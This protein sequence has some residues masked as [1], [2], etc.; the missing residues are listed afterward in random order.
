MSTR[1]FALAWF[2]GLS[3]ISGQA[4]ATTFRG[5]SIAATAGWFDTGVHLEA[6]DQLWISAT[7]SASPNGFD[8]F[9]GPDGDGGN[10]DTCIS[11]LPGSRYAL[12]GRIG[13]GGAPFLVGSS[14]STVVSESGALFLGFNDDFHGDNAGSFA[15]DGVVNPLF[16]DLAIAA[17][18]GWV[19]TGIEVRAGDLLSISATGSASPNGVD[20]FQGP[21][22]DGGNCDTCIVM[23]PGSRYALVGRIG[24]GGAPFIVGSSFSA[25]V[26]DAG[27]LFLGFNDDFHGDNAGSYVV[28]G[29]VALEPVC[30]DSVIADGAEEC[31]DGDVSPGDGCSDVCQVEAGYVCQGEPSVCPEPAAWG[32]SLAAAIA[33]A[34]TR[35]AR[36]RT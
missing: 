23:L 31:D 36:R 6:G 2:A 24:A 4:S 11:T 12:V 5:L 20:N 35:R 16:G 15:A 13:A 7:G 10:C 26:S 17:D 32:A 18:A 21:D 25:T 30:G 3:L 1:S 22:G 9:Q 27:I 34:T 14:F 29:S 33:L 8:N 28:A 19:S